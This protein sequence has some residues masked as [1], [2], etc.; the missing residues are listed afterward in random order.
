ME[1]GFAYGPGLLRSGIR[2]DLSAAQIRRSVWLDAE[3]LARYGRLGQLITDDNQLLQWRTM[4][5]PADS[6]HSQTQNAINKAILERVT[7]RSAF[8]LR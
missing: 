1:K 2:R 8:S 5:P 7:R 4:R 6:S 3:A